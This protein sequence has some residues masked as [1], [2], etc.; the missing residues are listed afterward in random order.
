MGNARVTANTF[1]L[2]E[3][4]TKGP[5]LR[6]KSTESENSQVKTRASIMVNIS[7]CRSVGERDQAWRRDLCVCKQRHLFGVVDFR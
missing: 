7:L 6:T 2:M 3:I 4:D 1:T 5:L